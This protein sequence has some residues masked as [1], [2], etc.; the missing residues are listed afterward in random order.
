MVILI[1]GA[2]GFI[3]SRLVGALRAAG[4]RVIVASRRVGT[5]GDAVAADFTRDL[6]PAAWAPRLQGVD[7]VINAVGI[8]REQGAQTFENI[9]TRAPRALF[10]ACAA[11]GVKKIIQISA[12]GADRGRSRYFTSK[13]AADEYLAGL[14]LAWTIVQPSLVFGAGGASAAMFSLLASLPLVP[15]PGG[16]QQRIQP[17]HVDDLVAAICELTETSA[18][19]R[20]R[21]VLAGPEPLTLK[22]FLGT[23]RARMQ[24]PP[25][26]FINIPAA[27]MHASAA[28]AE[29]VP[30]SL[31]D[32][33]TLSML[34]AGNTGSPE[35]TQRLLG[36]APRAPEQLI[37]DGQREALLTK[38]QLAWLLPLL[39]ISIA[40]V[41]IWTGIVSLGW[42]PTEASYELLARVGIT[43]ALAPVMLYGAAVLDLL[44]GI[45]ILVLPRRGWLW[46]L[47]LAVIGGYTL[48]ITFKL[49]EFWLHP[50]GP[51]S[52]NLVMLAAIYLLYTLEG[53]WNTSS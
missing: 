25:A 31:L 33:E 45:A 18:M 4:H 14:P 29:F 20:R 35:D 39:R 27:V 15:L 24:L 51:L 37:A 43:G 13:H 6:D 17:I 5:G 40:L 16:G 41:W 19:N 47:Q 3:G 46:L 42:Y 12:L 50:Y 23:L 8:I 10:S 22:D 49:P 26:R 52:K 34:N 9:H 11:T 32:R 1:T 36:R 53:R 28:V 30:G 21:V 7:V 2:T 44:I 48:I 38:A